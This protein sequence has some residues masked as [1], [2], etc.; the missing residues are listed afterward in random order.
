MNKNDFFEYFKQN[1]SKFKHNISSN[2]KFA[3]VDSFGVVHNI[4]YLFWL[5]WARTEY[6]KTIGIKINPHTFIKEFPIMVI[7]SE[8]NYYNIA[9]FD[10]KY[11]VHTRIHKIGQSS[12]VF[13]NIIT[14][15]DSIP[16]VYAKS[17]LV[18]VDKSEIKKANLP[19]FARKCIID[20]EKDNLEINEKES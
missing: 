16:L 5:E 4:Q 13:E 10:D 11:T 9:Q 19:D 15:F 12:I 7:Q 14:K 6:F 2:V 20:F 18:Y 17:I 1:I 8:I 3:E